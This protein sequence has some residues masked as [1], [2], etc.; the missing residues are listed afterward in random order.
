MKTR[1]LRRMTYGIIAAM[2]AIQVNTVRA[3]GPSLVERLGFP[4]DAK[5]LI[6]NADD[7][8]MNHTGTMATVGAMKTGGV[9]STT[10]MVPCPWFPLG[11]ELA[12]ENKAMNVGVHLTL[13]SEWG[14]YKW[15]PVLGP[16]AVPGL[17]DKQGYLY[18]DVGWVYQHANL[19][20]VERELRAQ[21]DKALAAGVDVT[22][23]DSHMGTLQYNPKYHEVYLKV[24]HDYRLP[25]RLAGRDLM[26][27]ALGGY[28]LDMAAE[29]GVL[30]PEKLYMGD[31]E[32]IEATEAFWSDQLRGLE[33][34]KV[35]EMYIHCGADTP[36]MRATTGSWGR[37]TADTEFFSRPETLAL[38]RE[39]GI[40]LLSYRELRHLMREGTP[41]PRVPGY[42]WN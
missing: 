35:S 13:T 23:I 11:A 16:G 30:G 26:T 42:G 40:E 3:D 7:F 1:I 31:P 37:R 18:P 27:K 24:A 2:C 19:D 10:L 21:I 22:H 29:L 9:T 20:E 25:C 15:G 5:V 32:S 4:A 39:L 38:I 36:E 8:G 33:P 14:D 12:R 41:M 17:A 28:L 6:I 34:G